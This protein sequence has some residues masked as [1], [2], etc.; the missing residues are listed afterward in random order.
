MKLTLID[1]AGT[2]NRSFALP[3]GETLIGR[4]PDCHIVLDAPSIAPRHARV[5]S[6][7][8]RTVIHRVSDDWPVYVNGEAVRRHVLADGDELELAHYRL[9]C[10]AG[11]VDE[12]ADATAQAVA[13]DAGDTGGADE[14]PAPES[15]PRTESQY[16]PDSV[17]ED[18]AEVRHEDGSP[19]RAP[20]RFHLEIL[21]GINR[22]R[23]VA[24]TRDRAVL[25]F[26]RERLLEINRDDD[27]LAVRLAAAD[28]QAWLNGAPVG[29]QFTP[30]GNGDLLSVSRIDIRIGEEPSV[31]AP[32]R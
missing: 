23:R 14:A 25:G 12:A 17:L 27:G 16:E 31:E 13:G 21:S 6:V 15:E 29:D 10:A 7:N 18:A 22:G 5:F 8:D 32:R 20:G 11:T 4:R 28:A 30:A 24:L 9:R 19:A 2:A 1:P 26:N 3:T